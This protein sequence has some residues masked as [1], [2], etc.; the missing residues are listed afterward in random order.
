MRQKYTGEQKLFNAECG[1]R[2]AISREV[3]GLTQAQFA[4]LLGLSRTAIVNLE[5]G[6]QGITFY[7]AIK[8]SK[9]LKVPIKR[10]QPSAL[11]AAAR[12]PR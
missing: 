2:I 7:Q 8:I 6:K 3:R 9:I 11:L 5:Q 12:E 10:I 4:E 1:M